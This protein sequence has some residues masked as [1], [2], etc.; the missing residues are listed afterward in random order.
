MKRKSFLLASLAAVR[1]N[2]AVASSLLSLKEPWVENISIT[3]KEH[4][5]SSMTEGGTHMLCLR[6][7]S[8]CAISAWQ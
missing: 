7:S 5:R 4:D 2:D 1:F 6:A 8:S 3:R